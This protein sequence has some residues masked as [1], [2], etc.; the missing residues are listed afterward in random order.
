MNVYMASTNAALTF[1]N[2]NTRWRRVV[3]FRTR[4]LYLSE[5]TP[6]AT[7]QEA[8]CSG[9]LRGEKNLSP[10]RIRTTEMDVLEQRGTYFTCPN[11]SPGS[12]HLG[13]E[14]NLF[15]L[16]RFEPRTVDPVA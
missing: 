1:L 7:E 10:A 6:V 4:P 14:K 8:G 16:P 12:R 2:L 11:S 5:G 15:H 13:A 9:R 3:N